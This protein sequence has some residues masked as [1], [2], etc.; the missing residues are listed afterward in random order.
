MYVTVEATGFIQDFL[1][2]GGEQLSAVEN[3]GPG[4]SLEIFGGNDYLRWCNL[5]VFV[6]QTIGLV[7]NCFYWT[8]P[9]Y[10]PFHLA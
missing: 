2:G 7:L 4:S 5:E 6:I 3:R 10:N 8:D 1:L 9:L